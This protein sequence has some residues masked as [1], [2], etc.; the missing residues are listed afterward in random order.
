MTPLT[1]RI[2]GVRKKDLEG[3]SL[4]KKTASGGEGVAIS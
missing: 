2:M 4:G 1:Q 3:G